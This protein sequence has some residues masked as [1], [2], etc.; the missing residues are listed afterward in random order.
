MEFLTY[1]IWEYTNSS[2]MNGCIITRY[3][4]DENEDSI[5]VPETIDG[6][7]VKGLGVGMAMQAM[8]CV[9]MSPY[10]SKKIK[11]VILPSTLEIIDDWA[12]MGCDS[13]KE[14]KLPLGLKVIGTNA[15]YKCAFSN[16]VLP[17]G[18]LEI[19][20]GAF[21]ECSMLKS[22]IIPSTVKSISMN[23]FVFCE[24]LEELIISEGVESIEAG[25]FIKTNLKSV[26]LPSTI[27]AINTSDFGSFDNGVTITGPYTT[28]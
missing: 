28:R 14:M 4:G 19:G 3:L 10:W 22:I 8:G 2:K 11:S 12:F 16:I 18:L 6:R 21:Q 7:S 25:A 5:V 13:L 17:E 9:R 23:A 15:F 1:G 26:Y 27:K 24:K 20:E